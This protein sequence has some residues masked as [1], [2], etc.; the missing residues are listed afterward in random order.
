MKPW[1]L[2][3]ASTLVLLIA[4]IATVSTGRI[5]PA[6]PASTPPRVE[7]VSAEAVPAAASAALERSRAISRGITTIKLAMALIAGLLIALG[8]RLRRRG[9]ETRLRRSRRAAL[10]L[11]AVV[12]FLASY[13]FF[14]FGQYA[15]IHGH[16]FFHYYLGAKYFPELGYFD[17]YE[18]AVVA[19]SEATPEQSAEPRV[20]RDLRDIGRR[21]T[22]V[23]AQSAAAC[24]A[25]FTPDAW[26]HF[27]HDTRAIRNLLPPGAW[28]RVI[29]DQGLNASPVWILFGHAMAWLVPA[30][31]ASLR[32]YARL[33]LLLLASAFA[34]VA[35]AF[36]LQGFS[37]A[38]IAWSANPL[39]RYEWI[40]DAPLR[41][42]WFATM[43]IGLCL[44]ARR[45]IHASAVLMATSALLRL[46]PL[47]YA[48]G[49][50][51][52]QARDALATRR[53]DA[54]F[55]RF[56][57]SGLA[58]GALLIGVSV[59][60]SGRGSAVIP[61]FA[62]NMSAYSDLKAVNSMGWQA[63]LTYNEQ[64]T[65]PRLVGDRLVYSESD[66]MAQNRRVFEARRGLYWLGVAL[67]L[68]LF[69]RALRDAEDWEAAALGVVG[70]LL[71]TQAAQYYMSCMVPLALL[72][73]GR[74][75]V[76]MALMAT[77][78]A[79]GAVLLADG[80]SAR[81]FA[82][83]SALALTLVGYVLIELARVPRSGRHS[84]QPRG[85]LANQSG[86]I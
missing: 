22:I 81:A 28:E 66:R 19:A 37:L 12:A 35:W 52:R 10:L 61:E 73:L 9:H 64:P 79:W 56:V 7:A 6:F 27:S 72:G 23:P 13:N 46:F 17:L 48:L 69:W 54:D 63:L 65:P 83:C 16:E 11:T 15:G 74:P 41:Q 67:Y 75:R 24:H 29:V 40:G 50:A 25:L 57:A 42:L 60:V 70:I 84:D 21:R 47:F 4:A 78:A 14:A 8:E 59:W 76:A 26:Q 34:A 32:L 62:R 45:R 30:E 20:I 36:G 86:S 82:W 5:A 18:C 85:A 3:A 39:A 53:L 71:F 58:A 51:A 2:P 80:E 1:W 55:V 43:L 44:L 31:P 38:V 77:L 33:D 49:Y 68:A